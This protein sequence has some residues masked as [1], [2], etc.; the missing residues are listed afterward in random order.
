MNNDKNLPKV[1]ENIKKIADETKRD[2]MK[3]FGKFAASVPTAGFVL[4]TMGTSQ[5]AIASNSHG[6]YHSRS[7][8][9]SGYDDD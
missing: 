5:L 1:E 6:K 9:D 4:M 7:H 2:F 8:Q 3:K